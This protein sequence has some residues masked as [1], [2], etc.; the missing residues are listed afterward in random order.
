M[1]RALDL[2]G[3]EVVAAREQL[4][5]LSLDFPGFELQAD[6]ITL[7][8]IKLRAESFDPLTMHVNSEITAIS[9]NAWTS[10]GT[11]G[12]ILHFL[13]KRKKISEMLILNSRQSGKHKYK[14]YRDQQPVAHFSKIDAAVQA[15]DYE[16]ERL[17]AAAS[18]SARIN[19]AWRLEPPDEAHTN[20]LLALR[21]P[22]SAHNVGEALRYIAFAAYSRK[23]KLVQRSFGARCGAL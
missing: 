9:P 20:E 18:R 5:Q 21:P 4:A 17:G 14:V 2:Y 3:E 11:A 7:D 6:A 1:P 19:A 23:R 15:V 13:T 22:R 8:E 10:L 12:L 16:I